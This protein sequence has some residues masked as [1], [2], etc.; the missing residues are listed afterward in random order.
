MYLNNTCGLVESGITNWFL[1]CKKTIQSSFVYFFW[2]NGKYL[3]SCILLG[4]NSSYSVLE[5]DKVYL[6]EVD[7][8]PS[9]IHTSESGSGITSQSPS[10][11]RSTELIFE[12]QVKE[13]S[14]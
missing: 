5:D 3:D 12:M 4:P 9:E 8:W 11:S 2:Q 13:V 7:V 1:F 10:V 6:E 14:L